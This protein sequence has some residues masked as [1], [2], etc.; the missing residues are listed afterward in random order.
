MNVSGRPPGWALAVVA[1][2]FPAL[3]FAYIDPG[4]GAYVVQTVIAVVGAA[5]FYVSRPIRFIK[6]VFRRRIKRDSSN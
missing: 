1:L 6:D 5:L 4:T 3:A 2:S